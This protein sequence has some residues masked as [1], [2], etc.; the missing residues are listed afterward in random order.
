MRFCCFGIRRS[1]FHCGSVSFSQF[2]GVTGPSQGIVWR[3]KQP[4]VI[5][6]TWLAFVQEL[7]TS[8]QAV[9]SLFG[10]F[11]ST[12]TANNFS[13]AQYPLPQTQQSILTPVNHCPGLLRPFIGSHTA[14]RRAHTH[15]HKV[16]GEASL[17]TKCTVMLITRPCNTEGFHEESA[18]R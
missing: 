1:W 18:G 2:Q 7:K 6:T 13:D 9:S 3:I 8:S 15:T 17:G 16:V 14:E 11:F 12:P 10:V 5:L 4:I